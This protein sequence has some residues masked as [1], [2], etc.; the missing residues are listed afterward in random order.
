MTFFIW[1]LVLLVVSYTVTAL[2]TKAPAQQAPAVLGD[3]D[4]PQA[5]EGTPQAVFFGDC[6]TNGWMILY[7]GN[8]STTKVQASSGKK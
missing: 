3:F 1:A 7:Y 6:W 2:T 8:Y 4:F 5:D